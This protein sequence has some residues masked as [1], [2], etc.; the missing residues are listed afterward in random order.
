MSLD[1][2][3][4]KLTQDPHCDFLRARK[5]DGANRPSL[6]AVCFLTVLSHEVVKLVQ[7]LRVLR[8]RVVGWMLLWTGLL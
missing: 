1:A 2:L 3:G 6:C 7:S 8:R 4:V 5:K